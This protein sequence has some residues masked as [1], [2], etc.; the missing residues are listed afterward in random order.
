MRL[1]ALILL[2]GLLV[3][4]TACNDSDADAP[5]AT[6]TATEAAVDGDA[7]P[8]N[9][10]YAIE[11]VEVTLVGGVAEVEAA[12]GSASKV[13]TRYFGNEATGDLNG[14]GRDDVALIV[15]QEGGGSGTFFYA[16]AVFSTPEGYVG[17]NGIL[18]GDRIA[19]Q[20]TAIQDGE[21]VVNYADR[22]EGEPMATQP[23][24]GVSK[25]LIVVDGTLTEIQPADLRP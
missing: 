14:D 16:V 17:T 8:Q 6:P 25:H 7:D 20:T 3:G 10:T 23:S 21:I 18:L 11:G 13:T 2:A 1:P 4:V 19:P 24:V 15:T 22:A 12:P 9:M 5:A